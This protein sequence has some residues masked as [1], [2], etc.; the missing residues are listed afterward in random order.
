MLVIR[1]RVGETLVI[2]EEIELEI[3]EISGSQVKVGIRA[4]RE[5]AVLRKEIRLTMEQ[6]QAAAVRALPAAL[7]L[8]RGTLARRDSCPP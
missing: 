1:R 2:G 8:L 4:P 7:E 3:L 6:N 5:I